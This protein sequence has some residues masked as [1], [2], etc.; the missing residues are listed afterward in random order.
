MTDRI[1][2]LTVAL[3]RDFRADDAESLMSAI[4]NLRGVQDVT[5]LVVAPDMWTAERR[6]DEAWRKRILKLLEETHGW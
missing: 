4:R 6:A 5:P 2:A 3:D 1:Y